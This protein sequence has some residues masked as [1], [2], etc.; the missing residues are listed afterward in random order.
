M[1]LD[2]DEVDWE[3][4]IAM[5][6]R[7]SSLPDPILG[8]FDLSIVIDVFRACS[9][10]CYALA[11]GAA[12]IIP[13]ESMVRARE[14]K[15]RFPE[16]VLMGETGGIRPDDFDLGNSPTEVMGYN[17]GGR[18]FVHV[19]SAG[20]KALHKIAPRSKLV[21]A[22]SFVNAKAVAHYILGKSPDRV[23]LLSAG[24]EAKSRALE[25]DLCAYYIRSLVLGRWKNEDVIR[26]R[27]LRSAA[28]T[29]FFEPGPE[30]PPRSDLELCL[31]FNRFSFV[32][33]LTDFDDN[34]V[35][36]LAPEAGI[37][38]SEV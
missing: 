12:R 35:Q 24:W 26:R 27:I 3:A 21:G 33:V 13:V 14:L 37:G 20:T 16:Y 11:N 36:F 4:M 22:G 8:N 2:T 7:I 30:A 29:R 10:A 15:L 6:I 23:L 9:T 31:E 34:L 1:Q 28:A 25:D 38:T 5:E 32:P 18:T 19:T 17:C